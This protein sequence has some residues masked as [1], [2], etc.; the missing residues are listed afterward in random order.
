MI[1]ELREAKGQ[2]TQLDPGEAGRGDARGISLSLRW[3]RRRI[4]PSWCS[5]A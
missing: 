3:A 4:R 1:R 2:M 5:I